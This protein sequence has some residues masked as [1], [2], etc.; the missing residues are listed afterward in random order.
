ML[1]RWAGGMGGGGGG[2]VERGGNG[3]GAGQKDVTSY[4]WYCMDVRAELP[5]FSVLPGI[6]SSLFS[7][8][9]I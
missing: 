2:G 4:I 7:T 9:G 8:K 3:V 5:P 6:L 1:A